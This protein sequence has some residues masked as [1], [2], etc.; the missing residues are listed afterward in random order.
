M[1]NA[2]QLDRDRIHCMYNINGK[3]GIEIRLKKHYFT[4]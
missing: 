2:T 1:Y 3:I 4:Y